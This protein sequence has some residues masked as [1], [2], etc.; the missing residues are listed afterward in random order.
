[1]RSFRF[2]FLSRFFIRPFLG[3]ASGFRL[4]FFSLLF[5]PYLSPSCMITLLSI[6]DSPFLAF[7]F[8]F[9]SCYMS[10]CFSFSFFSPF[11]AFLEPYD[12]ILFQC[13][14][15]FCL[16]FFFHFFIG[17]VKVIRLQLWTVLDLEIHVTLLA[18]IRLYFVSV[19]DS[20]RIFLMRS[21]TSHDVSSASPDFRGRVENRLFT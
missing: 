16:F 12:G 14:F 17:C 11:I 19:V 18:Y 9:S 8:F 1:M 13:Y 4:I 7:L 15:N 5:S 20:R 2:T 10:I 6:L 3:F 21:H